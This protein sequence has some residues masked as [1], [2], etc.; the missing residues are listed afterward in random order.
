[1]HYTVYRI[2]NL[3][4]GKTYIGK[5]QTEELD[6]GYMGS[7]KLINR[8]ITKHGVENFSKEILH[9][10]DTEEEMNSKEKELVTESVCQDDS[11]YNLCVGG[12]GGFSY[13]N[14]EVWTTEKRSKHGQ[15]YGHIARQNLLNNQD[16]IQKRT[17]ARDDVLA[18]MNEY[19]RNNKHSEETKQ[20]M[21]ASKKGKNTGSKNGNYGKFWITNGKE[22]M[23]IQKDTLIPDGWYKGMTVVK[24]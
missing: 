24:K 16:K 13:I 5:H 23:M 2:T 11:T 21:S 12:Q 6:D 7:G 15:K 19:W 3:I 1:M 9:V 4:N 20:K 10:F 14:R 8:A 22:S 17:K 18:K